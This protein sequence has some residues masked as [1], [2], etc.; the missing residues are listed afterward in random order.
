[1]ISAVG[2]GV[3]MVDIAR[4][5]AIYRRH[6]GRFLER[7]FTKAELAYCQRR[8][9]PFPSLAARI[10]AKEAVAKAFGLGI[11][12][13]LS[14]TSVEVAV[15]PSGTPSIL[16]DASAKKYLKKLKAKGVLISLSHTDTLAIAVATL[17]K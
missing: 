15:A 14:W 11:G 9:N 6:K 1:M 13:V 17:V 3:D 4:V 10:A 8:T 12:T 2:L 7:L 16:L 5:Q